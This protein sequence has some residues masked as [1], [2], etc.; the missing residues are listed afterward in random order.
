[1]RTG[2]LQIIVICRVNIF[3]VKKSSNK[4]KRHD[5]QQACNQQHVCFLRQYFV[6][7]NEVDYI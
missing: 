4:P 1:M 7:E 6:I 2:F 5:Y 3:Y